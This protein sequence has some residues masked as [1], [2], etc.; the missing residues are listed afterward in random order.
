MITRPLEPADLDWVA[1]LA[2]RDG[3]QRQAFAPRFWR[4]APGARPVH[5]RY[6]RSLIEDPAVRALRTDHAFAIGVPHGEV[7]LVDD[8]GADTPDRWATD[9][10]SLLG[11]VAGGSRIRLV[12]PVPSPQRTALAVRLG[13]T[14]VETWWHRDL[15]PGRFTGGLRDAHHAGEAGGLRGL[16]DA[17]EA[18]GVRGAHGRLVTA[19][20]VYAPGGPVLLVTG[21]RDREALAGLER[22]AA[23]GG[24]VV[25]VVVSRTEVPGYRRT[26]DFYEGSA[27]L[28][29]RL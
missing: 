7:R 28:S 6:L 13:L 22:Q 19:P 4:R 12:C 15:P 25:S 23:A 18:G 21:F 29:H 16:H 11:D 9:G 14:L 17:S 24:A 1:G 3:E 27:P 20:P 5:T 2:E 8:A 10:P 26:C